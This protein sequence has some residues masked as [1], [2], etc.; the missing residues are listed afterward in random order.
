VAE[1][2]TAMVKELREA[3][4]AGVLDCRKALE[5]ANGDMEKAAQILR[6]KGAAAAA[7]KAGR[8]ARE[9]RIEG[10]VHPGNRIGVLVEVNCE[11]DFVARTPQFQ[12]L[13]HELALHIAF[14]N[15]RY[16]VP[17]EVP[18]E[19]LEAV[20]AEFRR[21]ALAE[22]K[23]EAV[24]DRIVEG[25]LKKFYEDTC[26]MEQLYVRDDNIRVRD[27]IQQ[28]IA[29][30]GENIIVRRFVRYELGEEAAQS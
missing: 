6:E 11:S 29:R 27:L 15:P 14:A 25:R 13:A 17:E 16:V 23:P 22:G 24:V 10:Y 26:L 1:I 5:Q 18:A 21:A 19:T 12:E 20:K 9:G 3:T 8:E 4:G 30:L 28:A 2:T 7:K